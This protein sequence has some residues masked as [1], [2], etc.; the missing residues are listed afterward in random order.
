[1]LSASEEVSAGA[2][3]RAKLRSAASAAVRVLDLPDEDVGSELARL[4]NEVKESFFFC[5]LWVVWPGYMLR[6]CSSN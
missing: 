4:L 6:L 2:A 5:A 3:R 1:M